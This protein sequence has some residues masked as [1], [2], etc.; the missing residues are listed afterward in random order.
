MKNSK[1]L[2]FFLLIT[3]VGCCSSVVSFSSIVF[4][5]DEEEFSELMDEYEEKNKQT[6]VADP[7]YWC[8]YGVFKFNDKMY[9]WF[10]EPAANGYKFVVPEGIRSCIGNFFTNLFFPI[11]FINNFLQGDFRGAGTEAEIFFLNTTVGMLGI[12]QV[13]Q[14]TFD[15]QISDEDFGQTLG[16]YH[17]GEGFYIVWPFLGPSTLRD[18]FGMA[19]DSLFYPLNYLDAPEVVIGSKILYTINSTSYRIDDYNTLRKG[20]IDPYMALKN[21]YIQQRIEKI[22]K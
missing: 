13:A 15:L 17:V 2:I 11:R 6:R 20:A 22:K 21:G 5:A 19:G 7:L 9:D 14:E 8:N 16:K 4:A 18:T 1:V 10:I 12:A 3:I